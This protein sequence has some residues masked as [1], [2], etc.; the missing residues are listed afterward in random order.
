[1]G[2]NHWDLGAVPGQTVLWSCS[3]VEWIVTGMDIH[4]DFLYCIID[5]IG[6]QNGQLPPQRWVGK[7]LL[8]KDHRLM[9]SYLWK[10]WGMRMVYS[11]KMMRTVGLDVTY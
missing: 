4:G 2:T 1:M 11:H 8:E 7:N 10:C 3:E 6:T 5:G 9:V